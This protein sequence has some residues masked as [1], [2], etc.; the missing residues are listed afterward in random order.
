MNKIEP[1]KLLESA[2]YNIFNHF[3]KNCC[4]PYLDLDLDLNIVNLQS[5][6]ESLRQ[7]TIIKS[8]DSEKARKFLATIKRMNYIIENKDI[9]AEM[10]LMSEFDKI[11]RE[12]MLLT[13]T[14]FISSC[15]EIRTRALNIQ[16]LSYSDAGNQ[17]QALFFEVLVKQLTPTGKKWQSPNQLV[18]DCLV[19]QLILE[20][21]ERF[22]QEWLK[23][24]I[25]FKQMAALEIANYKEYVEVWEVSEFEKGQPAKMKLCRENK[26]VAHLPS[27]I[28]DELKELKEEIA[29][30]IK[31]QICP[32]KRAQLLPYTTNAWEEIFIKLLRKHKEDY[33]FLFSDSPINKPHRLCCLPDE[34]YEI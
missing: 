15:P 6:T 27:D 3:N 11:I 34:L 7:K 32:A 16:S 30:L 2:Y 18:E 23:N 5:L 25:R 28:S 29:F 19:S 12:Y 8:D 1:E 9:I 10:L 4:P 14:L 31:A 17:K 26:K 24:K 20:A 21:F 33:S 13:N 22:D